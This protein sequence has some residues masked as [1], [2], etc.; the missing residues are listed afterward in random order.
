MYMMDSFEFPGKI[1]SEEWFGWTGDD[2]SPES[3]DITEF[4]DEV[5]KTV[6]T[7]YYYDTF[8]EEWITD[9]RKLYSYDQNG[10][11]AEQIDQYYYENQFWPTEKIDFIWET[12]TSNADPIMLPTPELRILAYP[13]PFQDVVNISTESKSMQEI[14]LGI[15]NT[16]GQ[17]VRKLAASAGQSLV[18]DG[19]NQSGSQVASGVYYLKANQGGLKA[20][21]KVL[22]IR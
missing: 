19:R 8:L 22:R 21:T 1:T 17:L 15:Y 2:W 4:D 12:Y 9:Y 20:T 5:R 10:N 7:Q 3:K 18:W 6:T 11:Q 14:Q 13:V 16:R